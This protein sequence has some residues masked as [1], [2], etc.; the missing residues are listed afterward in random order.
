MKTIFYSVISAIITL[1]CVYAQNENVVQDESGETFHVQ[2]VQQ[3]YPFGEWTV[4]NSS[5]TGNPFDIQARVKF[6]HPSGET[7]TTG[8]FYDGNDTWKFRFAG[9]QRGEWTFTTQ[10]DGK[11][12]T[13][14]DPDLDGLTGKVS[15]KKNPNP[16]AHGFLT[17]V[18]NKWVWQGVDSAMVPQILM[19][20]G[21]PAF[22]GRPGKIEEDIHRLLTDQGF[23]GFHIGVMAR[24]LDFDQTS[25]DGIKS[26]DPNPDP[27]TFEALELLITKVHAAGGMV[28]IWAWGDE[29]RHMTPIKWGKNGKV[30]RRLQRYIASRLGPLPGWSMGYGFDLD[31]WVDAEDLRLWHDYMHA[32]FG[33]SHFLGGRSGGPN[34][35]IDHTGW[36]VYDGLDYAGYEHHRPTYE[37]YAAALKANPNK[38][39]FSEDR[40]RIRSPSRYPEKDYNEVLTRRGLWDSTMAGGVANIWGNLVTPDRTYEHK[41]WIRTY[42]RFFEY[43]FLKNMERAEG[44]VAGGRCLKTPDDTHFI[45]YSEDTKSVTLNLDG[46]QG[47][48]PAVAVDC[49]SEYKE[50]DLDNFAPVE[51]VWKAPYESDWAIAIGQY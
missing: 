41:E 32:H 22:A 50:I 30:D 29:S 39:V 20:D 43:R 24:W 38:P 33:W 18:G 9:T 1:Q 42:A 45:V 7:R 31:E 34:R 12:G 16:E 6:V 48:Q 46:M 26:G 37:V 10:C 17:N 21:L 2:T 49:K 36:Q 5:Y 28:H 3:W 44:M 14:A 11:A 25:Y 4:E 27:K 13:S 8:M 51:D 47:T 35:G 19:Y 23:N 15:V 40:F